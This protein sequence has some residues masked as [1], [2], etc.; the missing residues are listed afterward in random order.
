MTDTE[1]IH[2]RTATPRPPAPAATP[3]GASS[4]EARYVSQYTE[5]AAAM[6]ESGLL[7]RRHLYYWAQITVAV[8][9]FVA[10]WVGFF[11]LG[12]SWWQ[13]LLAA[14]LG[15]LVAQFGFLGHDAAHRQMFS[16]RTWNAWTSRILAGAFAGLS[17]TWWRGKHNKHHLAPNQEGID[18]D[19]GPGA[20]AFTPGIVAERSGFKGWFAR[21]QGW[22]F[23]PLLTLEGINL[24]VQS[25]LVGLDRSTTTPWRRL[26]LGLVSVRLAAFVTV[27]F[28]FLPWPMAVAFLAVQLAVFGVCLGAAFAPAHKGMPIVPPEMKLDFLRRQVMVSRNI[29]GNWFVDFFMG[30]LNYQIEHHLF[31]HMPRGN[32]KKARPLVRAHCEKVGVDYMEVGLL[33]SYALVIGYLN[34]VGLRARDPFDCPLAAQLRN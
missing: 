1:Q 30:G 8:G 33:H 10:I 3:P 18:P 17:Y 7:E 32:L 27:V 9:S 26:E 31:P 5:L 14:A 21:H 28:V 29:R 23:F 12:D 2:E 19:I 13:L 6:R 22:F 20:I 4:G 16:S 15:V 24:H 25:V 34:N 11:L